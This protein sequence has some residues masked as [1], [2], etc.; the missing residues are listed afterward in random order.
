MEE[1]TTER[2][3]VLFRGALTSYSGYG[4]ATLALIEELDKSIPMDLGLVA[5][6][7]TNGMPKAVADILQRPLVKTIHCFIDFVPTFSVKGRLQETF[8]VLYTMIETDRF[9]SNIKEDF[10]KSYHLIIVCN[11]LSQKVLGDLVGIDKVKVVPLGIDTNYWKYKERKLK[12]KIRFAC[13]GYMNKR[14]GID[15]TLKAFKKVSKKYDCT[16]DIHTTGLP[17]RKKL[18]DFKGVNLISQ[19][20]DKDDLR[21]FYYNHD[22][23]ICSSRG[24]GANLPAVEFLS[25]GGSV[26]ASR[27]AGHE[28][29]M[30]RDYAYPVKHK[31]TYTNRQ[32]NVFQGDVFFID[33]D[34]V[35][36]GTM[37]AE[38][39]LEDIVKQMENICEDRG[40]LKEKMENTYLLREKLDIK[41]IAKD[42]WNTILEFKYNSQKQQN[43]KKL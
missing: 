4:T 35:V 42:F 16:L 17:I 32:I 13:V 5:V 14:K 9:T 22:V 18:Y 41:K 8:S 20:L 25:T 28:M 34:W 40:T 27:W 31:M 43:A 1:Y 10:L 21:D 37:W 3:G 2:P 39:I 11:K 23:L 26:I 36:P 29:F 7:A 38:P 19:T 33:K 15:L 30:S 6:E 24:E 12:K